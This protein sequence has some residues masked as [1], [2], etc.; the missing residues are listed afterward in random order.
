M[1][2]PKSDPGPP[3]PPAALDA[4]WGLTDRPRR[5][6]RPALSVAQIV[7]AAVALADRDGLSAVS[8][9]A[10]AAELKTGAMSLYRYV[11]SKDDLLELMADAAIG[12][13]VDARGED[14]WRAGL[15]RWAWGALAAYRRHPWGVRVPIAGPPRTPNQI[16]WLE[17]ALA[18]LHGTPLTETQK[19]SIVLLI[20][21]YVRNDASLNA[22]LS[23]AAQSTGTSIEAR[24]SGYSRELRRFTTAA[25]FPH[26]HAVLDAG[27]LDHADPPDD[28]FTFG[29]ERILDGIEALIT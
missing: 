15:R 22:D 11:A 20:S 25:D 28:E 5:G 7:D 12:D 2:S 27:V 29:L 4:A 13:S 23:A 18:V 6:P 9:H 1:S 21:G 3:R 19:M 8:M 17:D 16:R 10:V 24:M 14:G 26:V